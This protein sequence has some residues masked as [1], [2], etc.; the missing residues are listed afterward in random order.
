MIFRTKEPPPQYI[1]GI[2]E[3]AQALVDW[4]RAHPDRQPVFAIPPPGVGLVC[5]IVRVWPVCCQ[6]AAARELLDTF[7]DI[8]HV[9][10]GAAK[11]PTLTMLTAAM[12]AAGVTPEFRPLRDFE[13]CMKLTPLAKGAVRR[14]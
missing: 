6:N 3:M 1:A 5:S 14:G 2:R 10:G 9:I 13:R 7:Q 12:A 4:Q 11:D 8:G